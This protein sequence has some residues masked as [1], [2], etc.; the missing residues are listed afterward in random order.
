M[1][2]IICFVLMLVAGQVVFPAADADWYT[3]ICRAEDAKYRAEDTSPL[4]CFLG[5]EFGCHQFPSENWIRLKAPFGPFGWIKSVGDRQRRVEAALTYH[6][7]NGPEGLVR[8]AKTVEEC[9]VRDYG[10]HFSTLASTGIVWGVEGWSGKYEVSVRVRGPLSVTN[11]CAGAK[12]Y[13]LRFDVV[14]PDLGHDPTPQEINRKLVGWDEVLKPIRVTPER[15]ADLSAWT[16]TPPDEPKTEEILKEAIRRKDERL[17][18]RHAGY[19]GMLA[20]QGTTRH[21]TGCSER[22]AD[23]FSPHE[24]YF[25][26]FCSEAEMRRLSE[27][28]SRPH[29][30]RPRGVREKRAHRPDYIDGEVLPGDSVIWGNNEGDL[31]SGEVCKKGEGLYVEEFKSWVKV[32]KTQYRVRPEDWLPTAAT[33]NYH[34]RAKS[35]LDLMARFKDEVRRAAT[36]NRADEVQRAISLTNQLRI[37]GKYMAQLHAQ[38]LPGRHV[39]IRRHVYAWPSREFARRSVKCDEAN[40]LASWQGDV[41]R[42]CEDI[43]TEVR[44]LLD[45]E[46][47]ARN[48][49]RRVERE[50][51]KPP[52]LVSREICRLCGFSV[53]ERKYASF[54]W[55]WDAARRGWKKERLGSGLSIDVPFRPAFG[56]IPSDAPFAAYA[57]GREGDCGIVLARL[58]NL[59]DTNL[60]NSAL[61]IW[62]AA[63]TCIET[64]LEQARKEEVL[65]KVAERLVRMNVENRE[66]LWVMERLVD[67]Y[68]DESLLPWEILYRVERQLRALRGCADGRPES[69]EETEGRRMAFGEMVRTQDVLARLR[70]AFKTEL[71]KRTLNN[72]AP[73]IREKWQRRYPREPNG[74]SKTA[75]LPSRQIGD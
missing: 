6:L 53:W 58:V 49:G 64:D 21:Y 2:K 56:A 15:E 37:V 74:E 28:A 31:L 3:R 39:F 11:V 33:S 69:P 66:T 13:E 7:S 70:D 46:R 68:G 12:A 45:A 4:H 24:K 60:V 42:G 75:P 20:F 71:F 36:T 10:L 14:N 38:I 57:I 41:R 23:S 62:T 65:Q 27:M 40:A 43:A 9:F 18:P 32:T 16:Y 61:A 44:V 8:V 72:Q 22:E 35:V 59:V 47:W 19:P 29:R 1:K 17:V 52:C 25:Y 67:E 30:L 63:G 26:R 34:A 55:Y 48:H 51:G 73:E 50:E 5:T 54:D